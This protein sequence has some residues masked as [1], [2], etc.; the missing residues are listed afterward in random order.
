MEELN[1]IFQSVDPTLLAI[2]VIVMF[3]A[4]IIMMVI[5]VPRI[6]KLRQLER[7]KKRYKAER[8]YAVEQWSIA[9]VSNNRQKD[10]I[11][12]DLKNA[13]NRKNQF[14]KISKQMA[15]AYD[16]LKGQC[17]ISFS[18]SEFDIVTLGKEEIIPFDAYDRERD[19]KFYVSC[20][21]DDLVCKM[22]KNN[23]VTVT[24]EPDYYRRQMKLK[25]VAYV[26]KK[27]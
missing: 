15:E 4:F 12:N 18:S 11:L 14:S 10:K 25:A 26:G 5:Y 19:F 2:A 6:E 8:D 21:A 13:E 7:D 22:L 17:G 16:K 20:L 3:V 9:M 1:N 24:E 23:L 27:R